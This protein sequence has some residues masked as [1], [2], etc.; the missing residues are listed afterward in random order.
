MT[1]NFQIEMENPSTSSKRYLFK[2]TGWMGYWT[3]S[4]VGYVEGVIGQDATSAL[5]NIDG[6]RIYPTSGTLTGTF[7]LYGIS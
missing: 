1:Y 5:T 4:R 2:L 6:I 3:N 7:K